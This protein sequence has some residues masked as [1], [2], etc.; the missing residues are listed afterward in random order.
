[1]SPGTRASV[2]DLRC[3]CEPAGDRAGEF[4]DGCGQAGAD[5][6][7]WRRDGGAEFRQEQGLDDVVYV[8]KVSGLLSVAEDGDRAAR[9]SLRHE[10][11]DHPGIGRVGSL[12][13]A[14]DVEE[15]QAERSKSEQGSGDA[16]VQLDVQLVH[17][18]R[19]ERSGRSRLRDSLPGLERQ[20]AV[21]RGR[22]G[23]HEPGVRG[24]VA[25]RFHDGH[26][27]A[28]VCRWLA[29]QASFDSATE[30]T[31][32]RWNT[33]DAPATPAR[34]KSGSAT[35]PLAGTHTPGRE[36]DLRRWTG[37]RAPEPAGHPPGCAPDCCR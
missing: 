3:R 9:T 22:R 30:A 15:A 17:A 31:A 23:V 26:G 35:S 18:V 37:R 20:I 5:V 12:P 6:D 1:M 2:D 34:M 7:H 19:P 13:G 14:E 36:A 27:A 11:A 28:A 21:Y 29:S 16:G 4:V 24:P 33:T 10:P 8:D 25:D 32:A